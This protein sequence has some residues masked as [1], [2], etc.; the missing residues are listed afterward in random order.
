MSK[1]EKLVY[2]LAAVIG[3][4]VGGQFGGLL[5][6]FG[7]FAMVAGVGFADML[8][9]LQLSS[10]HPQFASYYEVFDESHDPRSGNSK[11]NNLVGVG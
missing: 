6:V 4:V 1:G 11:E 2:F 10:P 7:A 3:A 9:S 5:G 8:L